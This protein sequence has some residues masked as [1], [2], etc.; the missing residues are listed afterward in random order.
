MYMHFDRIRTYGRTEIIYHYRVSTCWRAIIKSEKRC[1]T[2]LTLVDRLSPK[3]TWSSRGQDP[4]A[5]KIQG[6][7]S[8][9]IKIYPFT[10]TSEVSLLIQCSATAPSVTEYVSCYCTAASVLVAVYSDSEM[11][12]QY[13]DCVAYRVASDSRYLFDSASKSHRTRHSDC[14]ITPRWRTHRTI[15]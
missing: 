15:N 3:L 1:F 7:G 11:R 13:G 10:S 2:P 6:S 14:V 12:K 9:W 5:S 4:R 8:A